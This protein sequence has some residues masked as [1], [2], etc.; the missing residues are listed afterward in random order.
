MTTD[1]Q[2]LEEAT[3]IV[4][5]LMSFIK[6]GESITPTDQQKIDTWREQVVAHVDPTKLAIP[7]E[8]PP[9][10]EWVR[11]QMPCG[12]CGWGVT[13][14]W[15]SEASCHANQQANK[16]MLAEAERESGGTDSGT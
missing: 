7:D 3:R 14:G 4:G 9:Q 15:H 8:Q 1:R 13:P 16:R 12:H 11:G 5:M 6:S 2:L 10:N